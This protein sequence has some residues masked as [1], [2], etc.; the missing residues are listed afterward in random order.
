MHVNLGGGIEIFGTLDSTNSYMKRQDL[1]SLPEGTVVIADGQTRGRG[2]FG[3]SF[4]SPRGDGIYM[5]VLL[6]PRVTEEDLRLLTIFCAVAVSRAVHGVC[7]FEPSVKW[8]NDI[9]HGGK[10][11][12]GILVETV[13][14][15]K[16]GATN[17]CAGIGINTGDVPGEIA[18]IATSLYEITG[19]AIDRNRLIAEVLNRL[20]EIVFKLSDADARRSVVSEYRQR[21]KSTGR[22]VMIS[23]GGSA[24]FAAAV[25]GISDRGELRVIDKNGNTFEISSG[26][27]VWT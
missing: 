9:T 17:V 1:D 18:D 14:S 11:F 8:V 26:E 4:V 21:F 19:L 27:V 15:I 23:E 5:S 2:R 7:G 13:G 22:E 24:P 6:K 16:S 20:W 25:T 12:C 3:R 10:K